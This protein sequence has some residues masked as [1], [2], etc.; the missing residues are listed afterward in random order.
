[1]CDVSILQ[2]HQPDGAVKLDIQ[3]TVEPYTA[4]GLSLDVQI[5]FRGEGIARQDSAVQESAQASA[6]DIPDPQLWWPAGLGDQPLYEVTVRLQTADGTTPDMQTKRIGLRTLH[7]IREDDP[8]GESFMFAANGV[9]FFAKG[10]DWIPAD[11]FVTRLT[12][13]D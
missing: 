2:T 10:A 4:A 11:T 7:L 6:V 12:E 13:A 3:T 8:W 5:A 1:L 9:P